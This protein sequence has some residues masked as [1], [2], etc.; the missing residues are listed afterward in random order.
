MS[1]ADAFCW[2]VESGAGLSAYR[3]A[4]RHELAHIE[5]RLGSRNNEVLDLVRE[6]SAFDRWLGS[7]MA[8]CAECR[9]RHARPEFRDEDAGGSR[10]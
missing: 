2:L 4:Q 5:A 7:H 3:T 10:A 1:T 6:I 8:R 9:R